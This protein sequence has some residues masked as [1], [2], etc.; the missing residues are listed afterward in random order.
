MKGVNNKVAVLNQQERP[1]EHDKL[2]FE[3]TSLNALFLPD[4]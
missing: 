3:L 2:V 4:C 1:A